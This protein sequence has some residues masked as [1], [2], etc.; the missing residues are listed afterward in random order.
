M[1]LLLFDIDGTLL[2]NAAQAHARALQQALHVV[3]GI[4]EG[5]G[6]HQWPRVAAAGRTDMEIAREIALLYGVSAERFQERREQLIDVCVREYVRLVPDD[7]SDR[8]VPGMRELL[9][10][11][12]ARDDVRLSLVTGNLEP[13]ARVKLNR[14]GV[15]R[16]FADG[17]GAFGSDSEDRTDLPPIARARAGGRLHGEPDDRPYGEPHP[18]ART[19]VIGDTDRDVACA[20][21]DDLRCFAVTTGPLGRE[22]LERA[23]AIAEDARQLRAL[24]HAA[25]DAV[26][27]EDAAPPRGAASS[28]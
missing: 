23:D 24:L 22:G 21:A 17:Q 16:Y 5:E 6:D 13:V 28:A 26:T 19:I 20:H 7:L 12:G 25:L 3:H 1:L 2:G 18:R 4:G 14:A 8:V 11:L 27:C 10:E 9:D 15:G